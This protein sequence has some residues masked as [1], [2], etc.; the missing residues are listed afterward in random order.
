[1]NTIDANIA[2]CKLRI[3]DMEQTMRYYKKQGAHWLAA[4]VKEIIQDEISYLQ[5]MEDMKRM[6]SEVNVK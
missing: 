4:K 2:T 1:M 3:E 5:Q 6:L